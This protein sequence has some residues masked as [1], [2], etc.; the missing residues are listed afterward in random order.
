MRSYEALKTCNS[1]LRIF[2]KVLE[3][4][5]VRT[6]R[7]SDSEHLIIQYFKVFCS[8]LNMRVCSGSK[9]LTKFFS[10]VVR[11]HKYGCVV[12]NKKVVG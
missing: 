12:V 7:R 5:E 6:L 2:K 3:M 1:F 9:A 11:I 10:K 8:N 4:E